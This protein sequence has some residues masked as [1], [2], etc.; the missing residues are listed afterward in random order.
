MALR[1]VPF[2]IGRILYTTSGPKP[3]DI[4]RPDFH[5]LR[6]GD[7][8]EVIDPQNG[9]TYHTAPFP[10]DRIPVENV[11][12]LEDLAAKCD[13]LY[14]L[15][16]Y[17]PATHHAI[18]TSVLS[19]MKPSAFLINCSRG[20]LVHTDELVEALRQGQIAGVGTDVLE[21]EPDVPASHPL[22]AD[23]EI[24]DKVA[25]LPHIGSATTE[26][27]RAMADLAAKNLLAGVG[28]LEGGEGMGAEVAL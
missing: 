1:L 27:R 23:I 5:V 14:V 9:S 4:S 18:N 10:T 2:G 11:V 6:T 22:L 19:K 12:K 25:L 24:R 17:S 20:G 16:S 13:V 15:A 26:A 8:G 7:T 21:G 3:F 28:V